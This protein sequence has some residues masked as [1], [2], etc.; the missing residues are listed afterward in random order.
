M[1]APAVPASTGISARLTRVQEQVSHVDVLAIL[2]PGEEVK[3]QDSDPDW[4]VD[5]ATGEAVY[6]S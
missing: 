3:A 5:G 2:G 4:W 1:P 6:W